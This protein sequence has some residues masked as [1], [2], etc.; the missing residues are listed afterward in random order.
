M[1]VSTICL[2]RTHVMKDNVYKNKSISKADL[3]DGL[4][5][6]LSLS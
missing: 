5:K 4:E 2:Y 3:A 1:R 6:K